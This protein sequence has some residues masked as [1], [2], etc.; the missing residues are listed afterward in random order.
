MIKAMLLCL[1]LASLLAVSA[2]A[3]LHAQSEE[4]AQTSDVS[5]FNATTSEAP[6]FLDWS[7]RDAF[8]DGLAAGRSMGP[9]MIP[10]EA[11]TV[12]AKMEA[13]L[14]ATAAVK[15][16]PGE[17]TTLV[18]FEGPPEKDPEGQKPKPRLRIYQTPAIPSEGRP[19]EYSWPVLYVG[20]DNSATIEVNGEK[21]LLSRG[22]TVIVARGKSVVQLKQGD[23]EIAA[24][25]VEEPSHRLFV[26]YG[27]A[28]ELQGGIVYR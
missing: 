24:A 3:S 7:G 13:Y 11:A 14:P 8:P 17:R 18:F 1:R 10:A 25:A 6:L 19:T 16:S 21:L 22:K 27:P 28:N 12:E 9:L 20:P 2:S 5:F 4:G 26:I 15:L 23:R